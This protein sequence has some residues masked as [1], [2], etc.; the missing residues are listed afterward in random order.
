MAMANQNAGNI[1]SIRF[2]RITESLDRRNAD[3]LVSDKLRKEFFD[4][5][6]KFGLVVTYA[7]NDVWY[8]TPGE[9]VDEQALASYT[10][11]WD[12][13]FHKYLSASK[14]FES[15]YYRRKTKKI[16]QFSIYPDTTGSMSSCMCYH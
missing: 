7:N 15:E 2:Q 13:M 12:I 1:F 14:D 9:D 4:L 16:P 8:V 5:A 10:S 3:L 6:S 11:V